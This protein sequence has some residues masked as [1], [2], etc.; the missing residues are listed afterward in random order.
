M[1][2]DTA[3][4]PLSVATRPIRS[5]N[6][7]ARPAD[8]HDSLADEMSPHSEV[9]LRSD[10]DHAH[11][12]ATN[13]AATYSDSKLQGLAEIEDASAALQRV[14]PNLTRWTA[15]SGDHALPEAR[16]RTLIGLVWTLTTLLIGMIGGSII[17]LFG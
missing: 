17:F 15:P 14:E 7:I 2:K 9:I 11:R 3:G 1:L 5:R 13:R 12:P 10:T 8:A 16:V 6:V 4:L